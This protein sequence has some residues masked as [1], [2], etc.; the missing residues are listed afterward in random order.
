[1][2]VQTKTL[3]RVSLA[4]ASFVE[5]S[6][7]ELEDEIAALLEQDIKNHLSMLGLELGGESELL[8]ITG[9]AVSA[10]GLLEVWKEAQLAEYAKGENLNLNDLLTDAAMLQVKCPDLR[11]GQ[12][13]VNVAPNKLVAL[14]PNGMST[15]IFHCSDPDKL[16]ILLSRVQKKLG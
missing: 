3:T 12:A 15:D 1:M 8:N 16:S 13:L 7:K 2:T 5:V 10:L 9:K 6:Q 14:L 11:L 4:L